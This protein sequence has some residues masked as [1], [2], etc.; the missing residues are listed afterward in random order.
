MPYSR[1]SSQLRDQTHSLL[2]LLHLQLDSLPEVPPRKHYIYIY[3]FESPHG[4][5]LIVSN[6]NTVIVSIQP[7]TVHL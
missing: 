4:F 1:G 6:P 7:S 3:I 2:H 5:V